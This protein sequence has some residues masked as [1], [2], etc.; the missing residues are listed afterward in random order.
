MDLKVRIEQ[1][2]DR[3]AL[4]LLKQLSAALANMDGYE[5]AWRPEIK[6]A[7]KE[8]LGAEPER[9]PASEG[10]IARMALALAA[11]SPGAAQRI[12][13]YMEDPQTRSFDAGATIGLIAAAL[14][15]LQ[16][17]VNFKYHGSKV[18]VEIDKPT[19]SESLIKPLVEKMLGYIPDGPFARK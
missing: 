7:L 14:V 9:T 1:L 12:V 5:T 4:G 18:D 2:S 15:I 16:L 6:E 8:A 17:R 3:Q 19:A 10:D 11:E 13:V